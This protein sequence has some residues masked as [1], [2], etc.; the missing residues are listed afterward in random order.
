MIKSNPELSIILVSYKS[1]DKT[2]KLINRLGENYKIIVVENSKDKLI[3]KK[4]AKYKNISFYY[5]SKNKGFAA[6]LNYG[7]SKA[8]TKF[9]LYL[10][11]D[12][13]IST[14]QIKKIYSKAKKINNFGVVT[15][16]IKNQKYNDLILGN[17]EVTKM[18]YVKFNTGCVMYFNK[19]T[20]LNIGGFDE[21]FFLYFEESD[22]YKRCRNKNMKIY[23]YEDILVEHEGRGSID[24]IYKQ[25]YE[26]L[27]S[28]HYCWSKFN[29]Y[30]KHYNY[31]IAFSKTFPNL[32]KSI[33][34]IFIGVISLN[35]KKLILHLAEISGLISAYIRLNSFYRIK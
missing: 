2:I 12:I 29:Y 18:K 16:K 19:K 20:F 7:V 23:L 21:S 5:P 24:S 34:G 31:F 1:K 26:V 14:H 6:G 28:W 27:R 11:I 13:K 30:Y 25:K 35:N 3:E 15:A 10:D 33:K 9:I 32:I 22:F 17:D 4:L 8:K